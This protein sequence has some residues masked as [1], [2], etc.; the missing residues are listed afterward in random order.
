MPTRFAQGRGIR[1]TVPAPQADRATGDLLRDLES[2]EQRRLLD[3]AEEALRD[4]EALYQ[5]TFEHAPIG[6]GHADPDGRWTHAN[7][8]LCEILGRSRDA[9]VGRLVDEV[10]DDPPGLAHV[11]AQVGAGDATSYAGEHRLSPTRSG[12]VWGSFTISP[13][14]GTTGRI[15]GVIVLV[16]DITRRRLAEAE[17]AELIQKLERSIRARDEFLAIAAHELKTPLTPL[18]L[19]TAGLLRSGEQELAAG[20]L[21]RL[22]RRIQKVDLSAGRLEALIDRL[23]DFSRLSVGTFTL[24]RETSSRSRPWS[25]RSLLASSRWPTRRGRRSR[26]HAPGLTNWPLGLPAA[27]AGDCESP[28]E[29]D[30]VRPTGDRSTSR[31]R[32]RRSR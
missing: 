6:I 29:C 30:Q 24:E 8:R 27:R 15:A 21:D 26:V 22:R 9:I 4:S 5:H 20:E 12:E 25:S 31:S 16:D 28:V 13:L 1:R 3:H 32:R 14:L 2:R 23:L 7:R 11:V 10:A 17:R 19:Q 18:R